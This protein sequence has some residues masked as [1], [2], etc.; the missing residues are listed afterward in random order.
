MAIKVGIQLGAGNSRFDSAQRFWDAV[1]ACERLGFD[2]LWLSERLSGPLPDSLTA[3]AGIAGRTRQLK[4]GSSV[5][6]VPGYNP[7][8]LAKALATIDVLSAGRVLPAVGIGTDNPPEMEALGIRKEERGRRLDEA[9]VLMK[10]LWA[11]EAVTFRGNFYQVTDF[12]LWPRPVGPLPNAIWVG[13]HSEA[14]YRRAGRLCDG[15]LPSYVTPDEVRHGISAIKRYAAEAG[16]AIPD[17]HYGA[18]IPVGFDPEPTQQLLARRAEPEL[19]AGLGSTAAMLAQCRRYL[20][21]GATKLVLVPARAEDLFKLD[22]LREE[23]A[24]PLETLP[25]P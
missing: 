18:L 7:V 22:S 9:I 5:L 24:V 19:F 14:A 10:R 17:D 16:R 8:H 11:E 25:E 3:L 13:G 21:A 12:T 1:D 2:S 15:W 20:D 4:F 6:V 23:V